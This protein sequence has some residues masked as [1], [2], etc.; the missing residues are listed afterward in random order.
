MESR[1]NSVTRIPTKKPKFSRVEPEA[2]RKLI[3]E[4]TIKCLAKQGSNGITIDNVC[5]EAGV[6]RSLL[7]HYFD[8]KEDLIL[9]T[10]MQVSEGFLI[11]TK[12]IVSNE[13]ISSYEKLKT[14]IK[15]SFEPPIFT[16][17]QVIVWLGLM[18]LVRTDSQL[19]KTDSQLYNRYRFNIASMITHVAEERGIHLNATRAAIGLSA[20]IDGLWLQWSLDQSAFVPQEAEVICLDYLEWIFAKK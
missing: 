19:K 12:N 2:R 1:M 3:I 16:E 8:G 17:E 20:Q 7:N 6:S 14:I 18:N 10:Y 15:V 4:A 5:S 13:D 11:Q 9:Q